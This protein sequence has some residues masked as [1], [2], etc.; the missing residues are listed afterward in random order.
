MASFWKSTKSYDTGLDVPNYSTPSPSTS[1][2]RSASTSTALTYTSSL[3]SD[4]ELTLGDDSDADYTQAL[5]QSDMFAYLRPS[6]P[7]VN[8]D[9][10]D[11]IDTAQVSLDRLR[12]MVTHFQPPEA[13]GK[14][15][16][17]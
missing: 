10:E 15:P 3:A 11:D 9:L 1:S 8:N 14:T 2:F 13:K 16:G 4:P 5:L 6:L 17:P 12:L 7:H